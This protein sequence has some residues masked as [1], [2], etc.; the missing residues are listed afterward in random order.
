M[1][2]RDPKKNEMLIKLWAEETY[3]IHIYIHIYTCIYISSEVQSYECA[4]CKMQRA[5]IEDENKDS[6]NMK[7]RLQQGALVMKHHY[8][9]E[10]RVGWGRP[11][12]TGS[13]R[14]EYG[15]HLLL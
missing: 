11:F 10:N 8:Y 2:R 9:M 7:L 12:T 3:T 13:L 4:L 14:V 5:T 15:I 1:W 6:G